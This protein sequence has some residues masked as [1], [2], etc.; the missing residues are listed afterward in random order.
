MCIISPPSLIITCS[1]KCMYGW[2]KMTERS[3]PNMGIQKKFLNVCATR[4]L[5]ENYDEDIQSLKW[6]LLLLCQL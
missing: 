4:F 1:L 6:H 3:L 5:Q 2:S